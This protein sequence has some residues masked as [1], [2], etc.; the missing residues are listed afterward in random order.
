MKR[1]RSLRQPLRRSAA[2]HAVAVSI[3]VDR[4]GV[5]TVCVRRDQIIPVNSHVMASYA[6]NPPKFA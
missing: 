2:P 4:P 6:G 5:W 3:E 1:R